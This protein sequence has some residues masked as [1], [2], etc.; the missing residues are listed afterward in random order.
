M[1][2]LRM[3]AVVSHSQITPTP[4]EGVS[5][6][7]SGSDPHSGYAHRIRI[8]VAWRRGKCRK[9]LGRRAGRGREARTSKFKDILLLFLRQD[10]QEALAVKNSQLRPHGSFAFRVQG[11]R[12]HPRLSL[13]LPFEAPCQAEPSSSPLPIAPRMRSHL[14]VQSRSHKVRY[15]SKK[16]APLFVRT[17]MI[18][19]WPIAITRAL[20]AISD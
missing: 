8:R 4:R 10:I 19:T 15:S 5:R 14:Q 6:P 13:P 20:R 7:M 3:S 1:L 18:R 16:T 17:K 2:R 9:P 11:D 12:L